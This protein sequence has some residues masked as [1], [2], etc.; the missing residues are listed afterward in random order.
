M[1][2]LVGVCCSDTLKAQHSTT[3]STW[4]RIAVAIF[5]QVSL[6]SMAEGTPNIAIQLHTFK[7]GGVGGG[8]LKW[9]LPRK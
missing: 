7:S 6:R 1:L 3:N 2:V 9:S 8:I 4:K 5:A